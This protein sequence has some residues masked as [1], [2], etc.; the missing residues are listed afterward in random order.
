MKYS[1]PKFSFSM[2][3]LAE[4]YG[5]RIDDNRTKREGQSVLNDDDSKSGNTKTMQN[6]YNESLS[7]PKHKSTNN[8]SIDETVHTKRMKNAKANISKLSKS[9]RH[10]ENPSSTKNRANSSSDNKLI[11]ENLRYVNHS[12]ITQYNSNHKERSITTVYNTDK[13]QNVAL[14]VSTPIN[15]ERN[16]SEEFQK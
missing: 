8:T 1:P 15:I 6:V 2:N 13:N 10:Y 12:A 4:Y 7:K 3:D 14:S 11:D 9:N 16:K 5:V